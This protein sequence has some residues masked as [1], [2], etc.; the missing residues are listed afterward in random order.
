MKILAPFV[1]A[2]LA[3]LAGCASYSGYGLK[4]GSATQDEVLRTMGRPALELPDPGGG[5]ELIYPHGPLGTQTF[6][7]HVDSRDVLSG[8][9]QVLD[10][11]HFRRIQEGQTRDE[12]LHAI[13]PPG[14]RM[15]FGNG[16]DAW[17]YRFIDTWGY[18]SE[19]N[20]SFNPAGIVVGKIAIR[21]EQ[22][23]NSDH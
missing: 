11:D 8:I 14:D 13:G 2:F 1:L 19:F 5:H 9:D 16:N 4:P 6:I 3:F 12:V 22:D 21:L 17:I 20:V 23:R 18:V 10:D 15:R 7:A